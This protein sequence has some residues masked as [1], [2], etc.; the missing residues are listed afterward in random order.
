MIVNGY[1]IK[2][3]ANLAGAYLYGANLAGAKWDDDTVWPWH[4]IRGI[5]I[6]IERTD[7]GEA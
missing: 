4:G 6:T 2:P 3:G 5:D 7:D 1:T